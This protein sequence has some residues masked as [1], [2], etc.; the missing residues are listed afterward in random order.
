M[1]ISYVHIQIYKSLSTFICFIKRNNIVCLT[2]ALNSAPWY[3]AMGGNSHCHVSTTHFSKYNLPLPFIFLLSPCFLGPYFSNFSLSSSLFLSLFFFLWMFFRGV[4]MRF[5]LSK[6][7]YI[8]HVCTKDTS[9]KV[10]V[11]LC[12]FFLK[13]KKAKKRKRKIIK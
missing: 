4:E 2:V 10:V 7:F 9:I 13:P 8:C 6:G 11:N 3:G 1:G 12:N 5:S